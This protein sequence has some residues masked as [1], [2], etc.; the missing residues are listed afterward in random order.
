MVSTMCYPHLFTLPAH[1]R[2]ENVLKNRDENPV[3]GLKPYP[4][5]CRPHGAWLRA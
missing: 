2:G 1:Q 3:I 4:P 5:L